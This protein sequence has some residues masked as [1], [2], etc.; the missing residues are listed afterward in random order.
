MPL[1]I[2]GTGILAMLCGR[3]LHLR[4]RFNKRAAHGPLE[5]IPWTKSFVSPGRCRQGNNS[6]RDTLESEVRD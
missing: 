5:P 6:M 2:W 3:L 4:L 1:A